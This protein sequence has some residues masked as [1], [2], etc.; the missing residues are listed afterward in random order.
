M[1]FVLPDQFLARLNPY[2]FVG[3]FYYILGNIRP[4]LRSIHRAVQLIACVESPVISQYGF[5]EI[6]NPFIKDV[7]KLCTVSKLYVYCK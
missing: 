7:N 1:N 3:M 5:E 6:L 4:E 2:F